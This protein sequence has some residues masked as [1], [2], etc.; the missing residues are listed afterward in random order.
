MERVFGIDLG[1]TNSLIA[2]LDGDTPRVVLDPD[3]GSAL[4]PSVASF[5]NPGEVVVGEAARQ[6]APRAPMQTIASVK[7]FMGLG[8][9]HVTQ[10]DRRRYPFASDSGPVV[11]F[12]I[13]GREYTPP[14]ISALFLK[15]LK[16]RAER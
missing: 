8:M 6:L 5:P 1:T 16:R 3:T 10:D 7:R 12:A 14:E 4:L 13:H 2:Y 11:R 9:E 15:E